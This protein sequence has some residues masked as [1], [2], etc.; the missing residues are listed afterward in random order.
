MN[1]NTCIECNKYIN[2]LTNNNTLYRCG[3][4]NVCSKFCSKK[5]YNKLKTVDPQLMSPLLWSNIQGNNKIKRI[6]SQP[7]FYRDTVLNIDNHLE[8]I[9]EETKKSNSITSA[10]IKINEFIYNIIISVIFII[11]R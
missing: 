4:A 7:S 1:N 10:F 6:N 3:D 11:T 5:R 9:D 2:I 8:T